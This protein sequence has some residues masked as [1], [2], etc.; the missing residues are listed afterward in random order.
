MRRVFHSLYAIR[1]A[2]QH[3]SESVYTNRSCSTERPDDTETVNFS[4]SCSLLQISQFSNF[5]TIQIHTFSEVRSLRF[6]NESAGVA[7][8]CLGKIQA[9]SE[10]IVPLSYLSVSLPPPV[11]QFLASKLICVL[12]TCARLTSY[13][14]HDA[15]AYQ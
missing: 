9:V 5:S 15:S 8:G 4:I 6:G 10:L 2:A 1:C 12:T 7:I 14:R 11:T 13:L 3:T